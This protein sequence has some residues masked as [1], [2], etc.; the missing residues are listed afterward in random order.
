MCR[1]CLVWES[2]A[3]ISL[4]KEIKR[5][6][7]EKGAGESWDSRAFPGHLRLSTGS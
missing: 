1:L 5:N 4:G 6:Q 3:Q 2:R 7:A